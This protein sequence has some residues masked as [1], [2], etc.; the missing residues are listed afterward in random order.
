MEYIKILGQIIGR[1]LIEEKILT[2]G[3]SVAMKI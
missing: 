1:K 3:Y 2:V